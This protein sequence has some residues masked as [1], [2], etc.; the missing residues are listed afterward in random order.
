[1]N[2]VSPRAAGAAFDNKAALP[3]ERIAAVRA[4]TLIFHARD[5]TLQLFH[6]AEFAASTIPDAKLVSFERGGHLLIGVEQAT[7]RGAMQRHIFDHTGEQSP[8]GSRSARFPTADV[9]CSVPVAL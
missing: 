4:P 1:M 3:N 6:N 8:Q 2:P 7:I 5:D 9:S